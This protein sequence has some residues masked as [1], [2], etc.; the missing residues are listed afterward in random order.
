MKPS[1][2][3][4]RLFHGGYSTSGVPG[5]CLNELYQKGSQEKTSASTGDEMFSR[6]PARGNQ[7]SLKECGLCPFGSVSS[8]E[9]VVPSSLR[10]RQATGDSRSTMVLS[11]GRG[12]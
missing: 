7:A 5:A 4:L 8:G 6:D 10:E 2:S 11:E 12:L 9:L 3:P 1:V